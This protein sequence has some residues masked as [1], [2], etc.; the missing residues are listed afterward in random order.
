MTRRECYEYRKQCFDWL[1]ARGILTSSEEVSDWSMQS[2][3][4]CHYAPYAFMLKAPGTPREGI[5]V[6]L[7]NLVYHDC[8]LEPWMTVSYTHLKSRT[9]FPQQWKNYAVPLKYRAA[10]TARTSSCLLY[11]SRCV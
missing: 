6:P 1:L 10:D 5:P 4:F 11:T 7:F 9:N 2:L 3:I 8:V